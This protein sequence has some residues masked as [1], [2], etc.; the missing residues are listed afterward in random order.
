M[1]RASSETPL[2]KDIPIC[3]NC[4]KL[5]KKL[6]IEASTSH[7]T[8]ESLKYLLQFKDLALESRES[9]LK[10]FIEENKTFKENL[11]NYQKALIPTTNESF[12]ISPKINQI[13]AFT[14][15][16]TEPN[17]S[18][19]MKSNILDHIKQN[20]FRGT[21]IK[22]QIRRNKGNMNINKGL[23]TTSR[24]FVKKCTSSKNILL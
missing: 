7:K 24:N 22:E 21:S 16:T 19:T 12:I 13:K 3:Q 20:L 2:C 8:I 11:K 17:N 1:Q 5:Q 14:F 23:F 10:D 9:M 18:V 15:S 6:D 4:Q